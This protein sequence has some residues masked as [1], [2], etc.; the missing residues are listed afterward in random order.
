MSMSLLLAFVYMLVHEAG[1]IR[2]YLSLTFGFCVGDTEYPGAKLLW[3]NGPCEVSVQSE[4]LHP[5][6][7]SV[8]DTHLEWY[9]VFIFLLFSNN[10]ILFKQ[11][12]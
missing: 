6:I 5:A 11:F 3:L 1:Q 4:A 8:G 10:R 7:L 9:L 2:K 12:A